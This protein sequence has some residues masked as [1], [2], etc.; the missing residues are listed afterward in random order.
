M[1][2]TVRRHKPV[3]LKILQWCIFVVNR[4]GIFFMADGEMSESRGGRWLI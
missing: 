4:Y 2:V 3:W 1:A